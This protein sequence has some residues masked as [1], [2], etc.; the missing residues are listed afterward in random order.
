MHL[1]RPSFA[2]FTLPLLL[3]TGCQDGIFRAEP[4]KSMTLAAVPA[5]RMNYRYEADV[6]APTLNAGDQSAV[7]NAAVQA[8]FDGT[9]PAE[10]L[11]RTLTSPDEK[12]V[13]A[14][15]H[16]LSDPTDEYRLDMYL[17][18]GKVLKQI[19]PDSMSVSWPETIS[20]SPDS[21]AVAFAGKT[22]AV[23]TDP[24]TASDG[25]GD[26][27]APAAAAI[28]ESEVMGNSVPEAV[29]ASPSPLPSP[30]PASNVLTFAS[31]QIY[32]CGPDG[33][34][35]KALTMN[36][37]LKYFYFSWSPDSTMLAALALTSREYDADVRPAQLMSSPTP[38]PKT[39]P[40]A[41]PPPPPTVRPST[42]RLR[43]IEKNGR[44]RR[45]DD[46]KTAVEPVWSPDST[47]VAAAVS[48]ISQSS[49]PKVPA[50]FDAQVRIYDAAGT[51]PTQA[52]IP[53]R[54]PLLLSSHAYDRGSTGSA[55]TGNEQ[56]LTTLP[57][58]RDLR[59][60]GPI[61]ALAWTADEILYFKTTLTQQ[62]IG[63]ADS[64]LGLPRWHRLLFSPQPSP[65][66]K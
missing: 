12:S 22:R 16:R 33:N 10:I 59:S 64:P 24:A 14:I 44:E 43:I 46:A 5:V 17:P 39:E 21:S 2:A 48:F 47:K 65:T 55:A 34:G 62:K 40:V 3:L 1:K 66:V 53:L 32:V 18:D 19:T 28:P 25:L 41:P 23:R 8:D 13:L 42:G 36:D 54:L 29:P 7:R 4:D 58:V 56:P 27:I 49:D 15:Y 38:K 45:L 11:D 26:Q 51:S 61:S 37:G 52:A 31:E 57:E 60:L 6:P 63:E 20:W 50:A 30:P 9:R 35:L